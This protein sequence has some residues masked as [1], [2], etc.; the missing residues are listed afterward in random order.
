MGTKQTASPARYPFLLGILVFLFFSPLL[1]AQETYSMRVWQSEN[2]LPINIVHSIA[3]DSKGYIW[4]ATAEGVVRFDGL[5]FTQIPTPPGFKFSTSGSHR[6][7][8][9][10]HG[11]I[12]LA[13]STGTL[14]RI[15]GDKATPIWKVDDAPNASPITQLIEG[16][17][18]KILI[19]K[20]PDYWTYH[21][22][23][24]SRIDSVSAEVHELFEEDRIKRANSGRI[25]HDGRPGT[26]LSSRQSQW[27]IDDD[28]LLTVT[29][30]SGQT[31]PIFLPGIGREFEVTE[32]LEDRAGFIWIATSLH[33]IGL[34]RQ[35]RVDL[36]PTAAG[37]NRSS[38]LAVLQDSQDNVWIAN[39]NGGVELMQGDRTEHFDFPTG[40]GHRGVVSTLYE[41]RENRLWAATR[42]GPIFRW[43][44]W[45]FVEEFV[46][47][48]QFGQ[49]HNPPLV[50]AIYQDLD[51]ILWMG[52]Q[53]GLARAIGRQLDRVGLERGYPG[54]EVTVMS[55]GVEGELWVG[56][57]QGFVLQYHE[58]RLRTIG[59]PSEL[60]FRHVSSIL[61][62]SNTRV[63]VTTLGSGLFL[64]DGKKWHHFGE[65]Q[66]LPNA[67]LTHIIDDDL[68]HFWFGSTGGILRASRADLLN[69]TTQPDAPIHWLVMNRSDGL[70]TSECVGGHNPAGW[71]FKDD[72]IWF[73][74]TLGV[75]R[76]DPSLTK[77][78]RTPPPIYLQSVDVDGTPT[79]IE[80][81]RI[82]LSP[83]N[84]LL[85]ISYQGLD[86]S[87]PE[88]LTYRTRLLGFEENWSEMGNERSRTFSAIPPGKYTFQVS[89]MNG[90]GVLSAKPAIVRIEKHPHF[91]QTGWFIAQLWLFVILLAGGIGGVLA[92]IRLKRRIQKLNIHNARETERSRIARDLHDDLGASLTEISLLAG[93][94]AEQAAGSEFQ[95]Q[96]D[97]LSSRCRATAQ[98]LDE[99]V[100]AVNPREDSLGSLIDYLGGFATE[101][102]ERAGINLRLRI[103]AN[104][105][106]HPLDTTYRHSIFLCAREAFNN[107]VKH[108]EAETAWLHVTLEEGV[109]EIF[110]ED[111]GKGIHPDEPGQGQGLQNFKARMK[112]CGGQFDRRNRPSGGT[113]VRFSIPLPNR[114]NK[115][116]TTPNRQKTK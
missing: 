2:G 19:L 67:R 75:V 87:A 104:L 37:L 3:Q 106:D 35:D 18:G 108:S 31:W 105:P 74:T 116:R 107:I 90:D 101:F 66:G 15:Q 114:S 50:N 53:T 54:G 76:V 61:V 65:D 71:R 84:N 98:A 47:V 79:K 100:W 83:E 96:L 11:T 111:D 46:H 64:Y 55:G 28:N 40:E 57:A 5:D 80:N 97:D 78:N 70:P 81:G 99:I 17:N 62:E 16:S 45:R 82:D 110:I 68:G 69:R 113:V 59:S 94:G 109:L 12:W 63:W 43:L 32:M 20:G 24:I 91:W 9:T 23:K 60:L 4:V 41:D 51:G 1:T 115:K 44:G 58:G 22:G 33:G 6:L 95:S 29:T 92:R 13:S 10:S 8:A 25:G 103:P 49:V 89:A 85:E 86:F 93:L 38:A 52:G 39:R 36:Q 30:D 56:T 42:E 77:V 7:F 14:L 26:L 34:I 88:K 73:P 21:Q 112:A 102:L 48:Q 27:K 72:S